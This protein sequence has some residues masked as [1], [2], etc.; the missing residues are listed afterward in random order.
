MLENS[1]E[2]LAE[3]IANHLPI[4]TKDAETLIKGLESGYSIGEYHPFALADRDRRLEC[5][6]DEN[7]RLKVLLEQHFGFRLHDE[8]GYKLY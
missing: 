2:D 6:I 5:L 3:Y 1:R 4:S 8:N 7:K